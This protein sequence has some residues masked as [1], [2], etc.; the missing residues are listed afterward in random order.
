MAVSLD[1]IKGPVYL[2]YL[3]HDERLQLPKILHTS[4]ALV[5]STYVLAST[6]CFGYIEVRHDAN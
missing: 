6:I 4:R 2:P 1:L 3:A 5:I